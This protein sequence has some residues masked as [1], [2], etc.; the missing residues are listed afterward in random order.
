[1]LPARERHQLLE[2]WNDA[3]LDYPREA[4]IHE[5]F[6][7]QVART[8]DAIAVVCETQHLTYAELN[9][10][11]NQ[12]A[13]YFQSL[14]MPPAARIAVGVDRSFDLIIGLLA[15][16]KV[17]GTYV[18]VDLSYPADR[19][20]AMLEDADVSVLLTTT[21]NS[22]KLAFYAGRVL[23]LDALSDR[24]ATLPG[25]R[26]PQV[27]VRA[28][29]LAYISF[30]SGSTGKPKGV[31]VPHRGVVR[32]VINPNY[33]SI[34]D[35]DVFLQLAPI[36][37]DAAT[38][39]IWGALLNGAKLVLYPD[40][41]P[42]PESL[43]DVLHAEEVSIL[44]LTAG[45]FHL[46][47]DRFVAGLAPV[48]QLLSGGDVL[49]P[50]HV[51]KALL[52]L[53]DCTLIDGYGPTENTTFTC[54]YTIPRDFDSTRSI[55]IGRPINGTHIY[56]LDAALYPVPIGVSGQLYIGGDGLASGYFNQPERTA[57][58]WIADPFTP[59]E[60]LYATGDIV[61]YLADGNVEF[62]GRSDGQVKIRGFRIELG[63]IE[64]R[65]AQ[66]PELESSLTVVREDSPEDKRIVVYAVPVAEAGVAI[67]DLRNALKECLPSYMMPSA[68]V[69]LERFPLTA[70][71]KID[72]KALPAPHYQTT[73][74]QI[75]PRTDLEKQLV[76]IWETELGTHPIGIDDNFFDLGGHSLLAVKILAEIETRLHLK[77]SINQLFQLPTISAISDHFSQ[78]KETS[79]KTC[80]VL[81]KPG[82]EATPLFFIH[83]IGSSILFYQ[84][85]V[86]HLQTPRAIY[87]IQSAFLRDPHTSIQSIEDL[88]RHYIQEIQQVQSRGSYAIGGSSFGG[89]VAYEMARQLT[90]AGATV[91]ALILFDRPAPGGYY[92]SS[93]GQRY[94]RHWTHL[95][96][97]GP[98]YLASTIKR[99]GKSTLAKV[100][101]NI[102]QNH[103]NLD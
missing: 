60:K 44:W 76:R 2:T 21:P 99:R 35:R 6:E 48:K 67:A 9:Q 20:A 41:I 75:S 98:S 39:E 54:C 28:S 12:L 31:C 16:L 58:R 33:V 45:L 36:S 5:L 38:F 1:L 19:L 4:C 55:P 82:N 8:P 64:G 95:I 83:A 27:E 56:I 53:P 77:L 46:M 78:G 17:G 71:G 69:L 23:C 11:A 14:D 70:N 47:V 94:Q 81:M 30:T 89:L 72:R 93:L 65:L 52:A 86:E 87:G 42:T 62:L 90:Q 103:R 61:R 51:K 85:L 101:A 91:D 34:C 25:D 63:E 100:R 22:T 49:S 66:I 57:Q 74:T 18:P 40:P 79:R 32:L 24:L 15:I 29:D 88:S 3:T 68:Y 43:A 10:R 26:A 80:L 92:Q 13:S 37:F 50:R 96:E 59:G 73:S 84:P 97:E 7:R 102:R